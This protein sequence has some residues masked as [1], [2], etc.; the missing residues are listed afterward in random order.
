M[1]VIRAIYA[2]TNHPG[3]PVLATDAAGRLWVVNDENGPWAIEL[4]DEGGLL[5]R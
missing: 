4:L 1:T 2:G 3:T 5:C